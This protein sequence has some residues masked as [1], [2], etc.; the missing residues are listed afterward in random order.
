MRLLRMCISFAPF[1]TCKRRTCAQGLCT[2][3]KDAH[4]CKRQS[5]AT[6]YASFECT[7]TFF[8]SVSI[9]FSMCTKCLQVHICSSFAHA[10]IFAHVC[11]YPLCMC[12]NFICMYIFCFFVCLH[13]FCAGDTRGIGGK[14]E[15]EV[16]I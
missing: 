14:K 11:M 5:W 8:A 13:K 10:N 16:S 15:M 9:I 1:H 3:S 12:M 2:S 7:C 6:L 4:M